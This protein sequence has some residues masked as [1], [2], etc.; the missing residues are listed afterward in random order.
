MYSWAKLF[1][2]T[3][4][5]VLYE[6]SYE[7]LLIYSCAVPHYDDEKEEVWDERFDANNP[8]NFNNYDE[9]VFV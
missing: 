8:N 1:N 9:E 5:Y 2:T 7:N 4:E 6:M 3:P